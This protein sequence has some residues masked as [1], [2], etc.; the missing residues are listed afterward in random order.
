[1]NYNFKVETI[2]AGQRRK[3]G[4]SYYHYIITNESEVNFTDHVVK[5]FCTKFL[6]PARPEK[7]IREALQNGGDFGLNFAPYYTEFKKVDDRKFVY[8]V[9]HP[10]TH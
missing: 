10:S 2:E 4:D 1:M 7:E 8:K 9:V 3:Y 6:K 5:E